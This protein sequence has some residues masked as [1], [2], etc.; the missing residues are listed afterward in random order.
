[1]P[2]WNFWTNWKKKIKNIFLELTWQVQPW[3]LPETCSW[4]LWRK[5]T[6]AIQLSDVKYLLWSS[7]SIE[8]IIDYLLPRK[9]LFWRMCPIPNQIRKS[10]EKSFQFSSICKV[11]K[12]SKYM[13][14]F[15][16]TKR[17]KAHLGM[18]VGRCLNGEGGK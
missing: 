5:P 2:F 7:S 10:K 12:K 18:Q 15:R 11:W 17:G 3:L 16:E 4:I 1:M 9:W 6:N 8:E 14:E 13:K